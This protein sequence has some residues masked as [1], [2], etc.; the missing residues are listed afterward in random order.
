[1]Q[2][3][4]L[5]S[6][7]STL[8]TPHPGATEGQRERA[9]ETERKTERYVGVPRALQSSENTSVCHRHF[10]HTVRSHSSYITFTAEMKKRFWTQR[11]KVQGYSCLPLLLLQPWKALTFFV[12]TIDMADW[13]CTVFQPCYFGFLILWVAEHI[14]LYICLDN[15]YI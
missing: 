8:P 15:T 13:K 3:K 6:F 11:F 12:R 5:F 2:G 14:F 9:M 4:W 1:M 7:C 10:T